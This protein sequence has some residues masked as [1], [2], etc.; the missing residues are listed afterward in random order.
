MLAEWSIVFSYSTFNYE[1]DSRASY[2]N[3][4]TKY[5]CLFFA[6]PPR[7]VAMNTIGCCKCS[8]TPTHADLLV[9]MCKE[10]S[11]CGRGQ[12]G[13]I[14]SPSFLHV[15]TSCQWYSKSEADTLYLRC[16]VVLV[17]VA[18]THIAKR[19]SRSIDL[20]KLTNSRS[21]NCIANAFYNTCSYIV[22]LSTRYPI[23][24]GI[25]WT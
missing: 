7:P 12:N 25:P 22:E 6:Y 16:L 1:L 20:V 13:V 23:H 17:L 19:V 2:K 4:W 3:V 10:L 11:G 18:M 14:K 15:S 21:I 8:S 5:Y 24:A 9:R